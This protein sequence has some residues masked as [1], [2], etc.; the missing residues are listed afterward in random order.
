MSRV[1]TEKTT[2]GVKTEYNEQTLI[3]LSLTAIYVPVFGV[4]WLTLPVTV[5]TLCSGQ[6]G[7]NWKLG[8]IN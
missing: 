3:Q 6:C 2:T 5:F 1:K 7:I 8:E 4:R